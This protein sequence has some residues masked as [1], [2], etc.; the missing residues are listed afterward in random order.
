MEKF[1]ELD[2]WLSKH[3]FLTGDNLNYT[4]FLLFETLNNHNAC[5][6]DLL[7]PF[8][9][10]QRFHKEVMSQAGVKEFV[11]SERNP[12]AICSPLA[13]WKAGTV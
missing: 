10:L 1:R 6:P 13:T 5:M 7:E 11:T 4:D 2:H 12:S 9:N 8:V 3:R